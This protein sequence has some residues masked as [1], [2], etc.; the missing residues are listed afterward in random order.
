M[1]LRQPHPSDT[2]HCA[3]RRRVIALALT[4]CAL[5]IAACGSSGGSTH[6]TG[7]SS[8]PVAAAVKFAECMRSHGVPNFRDPTPNGEG[9]TVGNVDK[10]S[11]A[12]RSAQAMCRSAQAEIARAKPPTSPAHQLRY[13]ECMRS[14]GVTNF[15]DPLPGGGFTFPSTV[16]P[17][18][19]SFQAADNAC[20]NKGD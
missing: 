6:T 13:A 10:R 14:H 5:A 18:S 20:G 12:F 11:P 8:T 17:Q 2:P 9:S 1:T 19:P 3:R 16:N 4:G 15:P 7:A